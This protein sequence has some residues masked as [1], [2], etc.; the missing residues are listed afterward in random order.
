MLDAFAYFLSLHAGAKG[1]VT[2]D[3][4]TA[5]GLEKLKTCSSTR[6]DA[7][8]ASTLPAGTNLNAQIWGYRKL[9]STF[10]N[11]T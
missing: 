8:T 4:I 9:Y 7:W 1:L 2:D 10:C 5:P 3:F 11:L 6:E